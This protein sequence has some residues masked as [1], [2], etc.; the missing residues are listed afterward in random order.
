MFSPMPM[1]FGLVDWN[2][3]NSCACASCGR[4]QPL[5]RSASTAMPRSA[6]KRNASRRVARPCASIGLSRVASSALRSR[7]TNNCCSITSSPFTRHGPGKRSRVTCTPS[8]C[9]SQS[10]RATD[11]RTTWPRSSR[12]RRGWR[13]CVYSRMRAMMRAAN[14]ACSSASFTPPSS[15]SLAPWR[16]SRLRRPRNTL[17][18]VPIGWFSSCA[19]VEAISPTAS[20]R[21]VNSSRSRSSRW[22]RAARCCSPVAAGAVPSASSAGGSP[23][24]RN[25]ARPGRT[26]V[27]SRTHGPFAS[28]TC[29]RLR[30]ACT[31][32]SL[33]STNA[34]GCARCETTSIKPGKR[35][36]SWSKPSSTS[37][38]QRAAKPTL[39]QTS[40]RFVRSIRAAP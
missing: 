27:A 31:V 8:R 38:Q 5:S 24:S 19:R 6:A 17:A 35:S 39:H 37:T 18:T 25:A 3:T 32:A 12:S 14:K 11:S 16:S 22:R 40:K 33:D 10:S 29:Q 1:P 13:E 15:S 9:N 7:F 4:P 23:R 21:D 28:I 34:G 2:G 20:E 26:S 30:G 36:S